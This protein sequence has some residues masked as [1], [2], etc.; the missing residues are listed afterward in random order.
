MVGPPTVNVSDEIPELSRGGEAVAV[1]DLLRREE[2]LHLGYGRKQN[3]D[4]ADTAPI[5][6]NLST[7]GRIDIGKVPDPQTRLAHAL[8]AASRAI[9]QDQSIPESKR[10]DVLDAATKLSTLA[11]NSQTFVQAIWQGLT[12]G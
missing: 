7:K 8:A 4:G 5:L 11:N 6:Y 3:S 9:E 12:S 1:F 10:R 2:F